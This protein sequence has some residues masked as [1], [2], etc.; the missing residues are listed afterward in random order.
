[1]QRMLQVIDQ[2]QSKLQAFKAHVHVAQH[3]HFVLQTSKAHLGG[4]QLYTVRVAGK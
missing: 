2:K 4:V 3:Q 1:M